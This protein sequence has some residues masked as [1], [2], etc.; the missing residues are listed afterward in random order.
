MLPSFTAL[1]SAAKKSRNRYH[2]LSTANERPQPL[3]G[4]SDTPRPRPCA[5]LWSRVPLSRL[6]ATLPAPRYSPAAPGESSGGTAARQNRAQG[7][8][9]TAAAMAGHEPSAS[10]REGRTGRRASYDAAGPHW[11]QFSRRAPPRRLDAVDIPASARGSEGSVVKWPARLERLRS[12]GSALAGA[13][14]LAAVL[15]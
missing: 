14:G 7:H 5:M 6:P 3:S 12:V 11:L 8:A 4:G 9:A 15:L 13:G 1:F 10:K 2:D